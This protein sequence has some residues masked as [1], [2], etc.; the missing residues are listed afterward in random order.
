MRERHIEL[1]GEIDFISGEPFIETMM[2]SPEELT[3]YSLFQLRES[4]VTREEFSALM[5]IRRSTLD[6]YLSRL[7]SSGLVHRIGKHHRR[8]LL[9]TIR[10]TCGVDEIER[11][12]QGCSLKPA[13]HG[14]DREWG[15]LEFSSRYADPRCRVFLI[16]M[17]LKRDR[18]DVTD[19]TTAMNLMRND[20]SIY[21][22]FRDRFSSVDVP[23]ST[24][25]WDMS[26]YVC[27]VRDEGNDADILLLRAES[28]RRRGEL[29]SSL[30]LYRSLLSGGSISLNENQ[31]FQANIG[32]AYVLEEIG[33]MDR[34]EEMI[35][36]MMGMAEDVTLKSYLRE[37][38]GV[39]LYF[40]GEYEASLSELNHCIR[41]F[42]TLGDYFFLGICYNNR[43]VV[44]FNL[45]RTENAERDWRR[46][47]RCVR[48]IGSRYMEAVVLPNLADIESGKGNFRAAERYLRIARRIFEENDYLEG[49]STVEFNKA[50]LYLEKGKPGS[51]LKHFRI[52]ETIAAPL[53]SPG[54]RKIR[55]DWFVK[56]A[57]EKGFVEIEALL[58]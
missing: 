25:I 52:S 19:V 37:I 53:P 14:V 33:E 30:E 31:W 39:F 9:E 2:I 8:N 50:L 43:G 11:K 22:I 13:R 44:N 45:G 58:G 54:N 5:G 7:S 55:R 34:A 35:D 57:R 28:F 41:S 23:F 46:S 17:Y 56:K 48:R 24:A 3:L 36:S 27:G 12:L 29:E 20:Q 47:L 21:R 49:I 40:K 6:T 15:L 18:F 38:K 4:S 10:V 26:L 42:T 32:L 1:I 16:S 51:A